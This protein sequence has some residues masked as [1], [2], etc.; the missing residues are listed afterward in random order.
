MKSGLRLALLMLLATFA[1]VA[2]ADTITANFNGTAIPAGDEVWFSAVLKPTSGIGS[3]PVTIFLTQSTVTFT[4]NSVNY[5]LSVPNAAI[6][7]SPSATTATTSFSTSLNQWQTTVP[8]TGLAGN[9]F[10][11]AFM[12]SVPGGL[13]GGIQ[14]VSWNA[15]FSTNAPGVSFNWQWAAAVYSSACGN[16]YNALGVKPT[17]DTSA[18]SYKNSDHAGT[19]ESCKSSDVTGGAMG[20]GG[21]NYTG[22]YSGTAS[23]TPPAAVPEPGSFM[24]FASGLGIM[25]ARLRSR[26]R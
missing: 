7:F 15:T 21:S 16:N 9:T 26:K 2:S 17:D 3:S 13:P 19:P 4:A 24:L 22:S 6:T 12:L 8:S 20:G 14:H 25:G 18:S 1:S 11:D 5:N 23:S 10:M